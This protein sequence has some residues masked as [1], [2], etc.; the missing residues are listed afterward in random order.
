MPVGVILNDSRNKKTSHL[1]VVYTII[2]AVV[3][4]FCVKRRIERPVAKITS[5][6]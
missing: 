1:Y 3:V 4:V 2:V 6:L 5:G